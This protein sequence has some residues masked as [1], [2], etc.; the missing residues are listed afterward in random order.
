MQSLK[1]AWICDT[2][3]LKRNQADA[4]TIC[5]YGN[6]THAYILYTPVTAGCNSV[7]KHVTEVALTYT[8]ILRC[9]LNA[10]VMYNSDL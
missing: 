2:V 1:T 6:N 8:V 9:G 3:M 4:N 10:A 5:F 7:L